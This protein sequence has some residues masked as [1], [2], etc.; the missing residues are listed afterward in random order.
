MTIR[1]LLICGLFCA[2]IHMVGCSNRPARVHAP[3][4]DIKEAASGAIAQFDKNGNGSIS[5]PE[6]QANSALANL[7]S[8]RDGSVG[9]EEIAE[10]LR[11]WQES[12][13][14]II[15]FSA[16]VTFRGRPLSGAT[17]EFKPEEFLGDAVS[18]AVGVT[19]S[20]GTVSL[21][22]PKEELPNS[23]MNGVRLGIYRVSISKKQ[24]GR[25]LLP[26]KYNSDSAMG[27]V[28]SPTSIPLVQFNL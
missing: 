24:N 3:S 5:G 15:G 14:G 9:E 27:H 26:A 17:V 22:I 19:D 20:R 25:E 10:N 1:I 6:L 23:N 2:C 21:S 4:I 7:D 28:I 12:N 11:D 16:V 13:V 8:N 18:T